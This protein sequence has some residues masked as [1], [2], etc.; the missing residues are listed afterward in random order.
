MYLYRLCFFFPQDAA[1]HSNLG[2]IL[3]INNKLDEA[4][5]SYKNALRLQPDDATTLANLRK[6]RNVHHNHRHTVK[7]T[8]STI[9]QI[10]KVHP[11]RGHHIVANFL[12]YIINHII[13]FI[14][15]FSIEHL[16]FFVSFCFVTI[17]YDVNSF[18]TFFF[19]QNNTR[20]HY[21]NIV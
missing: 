21:Y 17:F 8:I 11:S 9:S 4:E 5:R 3:H 14:S 16:C 20:W 1:S 12:Q 15:L 2:A 10:I 18:F 19:F 13:I 6:L 7:W